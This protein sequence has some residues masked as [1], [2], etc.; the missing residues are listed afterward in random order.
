MGGGDFVVGVFCLVG[1]WGFFFLATYGH[2]EKHTH[3]LEP[4]FL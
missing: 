1:F 3:S 2:R 4:P